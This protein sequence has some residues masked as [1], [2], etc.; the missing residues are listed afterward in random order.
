MH[1]V[2]L[3]AF[4]RRK[5]AKEYEDFFRREGI[6]TLFSSLC[7]GT[8]SRH[9]LDYLGV[10]ATDKTMLQTVVGRA[11]AEKILSGA[12][13]S[14]GIGVPGNGIALTVPLSSIGGNTTLQY[15]TDSRRIENEV[16]EMKD[17]PCRYALIT[18]IAEKGSTDD[19]MDAA[20]SA[21]AKGGTVIPAKGTGTDFTAKFFGMTLASEKEIVYIVS[22]EEDR[23]GIM[24]A[25]MDQCG[26]RT[27]HHAAVFSLPVEQVAG[28]RNLTGEE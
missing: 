27:R 24:R 13:R 10:E 7:K 26:V 20:R 17:S 25:V 22:R 23:E 19:I 15:L 21:G 4:V 11:E 12:E 2:L 28:F 14:M 9:I 3:I 1:L 6:T 18:V 5:Q 16:T 8:A